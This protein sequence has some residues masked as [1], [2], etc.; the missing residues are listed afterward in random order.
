MLQSAVK[1]V[2]ALC[3]VIVFIVLVGLCFVVAGRYMFGSLMD[4]VSRS[5]FGTFSLAALTMFQLFT[6]D[7]W[8]GVLYA[9]MQVFPAEQILS[10]FA[11][12]ALIMV[13]FIF[14]SLIA[15][16]LF[17]AVI[18]ENF[19]ISDTIDNIN[20]PGNVDSVRQTF[21]RTYT[22]MYRRSS[23]ITSGAV[24]LDPH[25]GM[26]HAGPN[27]ANHVFR[28]NSAR[29]LYENYDQLE[30]QSDKV[31]TLPMDF[32]YGSRILRAVVAATW[33]IPKGQQGNV[34][35]LEEPERVLF[36]LMPQNPIRKF[37]EQ[38]GES[39]YFDTLILF[40]IVL[41]CFFL[42]IEPPF[43]DL[44]DYPQQVEANEPLV[45]FATISLCNL[46]F[47]CLFSTEL[48]CRVMGQGLFFTKN[49][50]LKE[51]WNVID[52]VVL[53]FALV[54]ISGVLDGTSLAKIMRMGRALKPLRLMKRNQSMRMVIDALITTLQPIAYVILFL[55]FTL[56]VFG[57]AAIGVFGGK[58]FFCSS[59][60]VAF[61]LGKM[62]C[63][64]TWIVQDGNL[65]GVIF[66][67]V[68]D[69]PYY[70]NFDSFFMAFMSLF[71]VSTFKYVGIIFACMDITAK[72]QAPLT[73][74]KWYWSVFFIV[75]ILV[76][77][78]FVMNLF[79]AFII[80][81]FNAAKGSTQAEEIYRRFRRQLL[82]YRPKYETFKPPD[83][84]ISRQLRKLIESKVFQTI[85]TLC[86]LVNVSML[87]ADN[88][89]ASESYI[90]MMKSQNDFFYGE[91]CL[92]VVLC[93]IAYGIHM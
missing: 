10:Q 42:I 4:D 22:Q 69:N 40:V 67:S 1:S 48:V 41:S 77:A 86:V 59:P 65:N 84:R 46:I 76:G 63:S 37:F 31:S 15:S 3:N 32:A 82:Q 85:S 5:N 8:S 12:A 24:S 29:I 83:F 17:V 23:A 11:G 50:Y 7:S 79:V 25:T 33:A 72:D 93:A 75:Y 78:L 13:W 53:V 55:I 16:N 61:P 58:L 74:N 6:G 28:K 34:G 51:G 2:Q 36:V 62:E 39:V 56:V 26:L 90:S 57:L 80:D 92:E 45:P 91:L 52:A 35:E 89:D 64:G 47:T 14:A 27:T 81:G 18:I 73:N 66:P 68:W 21:R 19:Q 9:S 49:A 43:T 30:R 44:V 54:E 88:A 70:F 38:L 87:L 20:K 71:M 60:A